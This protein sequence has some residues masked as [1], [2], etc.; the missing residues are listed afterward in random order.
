MKH[1]AFR[2]DSSAQMGTGHLMRCLTLADILKQEAVITFISRDLQGN[3]NHLVR[4]KGYCLLQ[5][6]SVERNEEL[7][8]YEQWLTVTGKVDAEQTK[9]LL[10]ETVS[11]CMVI[12][13]Y[14]IDETWERILRPYAKKIMVIDDLANRKHNCDI[15]LDQ[16]YYCDMNNRYN[17]LVPPECKL[18]LGPQYALLRQEFYDAR[19]KMHVRDGVIKNILVFF[20]GSDLTNETMKALKAIEKLK[21]KDIAVN[22]VVGGSNQHKGEVEL[23]CRQYENMY[24]YCQ[25]NNMAD[26]MN[27]ADLAIGA[28]GTTTWERWFLGL[29]AIVIA[30]AENQ[31]KICEDCDQAGIIKYLGYSSSIVVE[32]I[33]YT[34]EKLIC[35]NEMKNIIERLNDFKCDFNDKFFD[36]YFKNIEG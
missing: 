33:R 11:D 29:P 22:V 34:L 20:G 7:Q 35:E 14:A 10:G 13:H 3:L 16:N 6:P 9:T 12:D 27:R 18:L 31:V 32:N 21:R 15:L 5:L 26:L 25:V 24:C 2:V 1:I 36:E 28:G 30:I 23:F 4:E 8:G 19:N 17:R